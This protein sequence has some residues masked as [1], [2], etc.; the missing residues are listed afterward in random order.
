MALKMEPLTKRIRIGVDKN[1]SIHIEKWPMECGWN[2][3]V[4]PALSSGDPEIFTLPP[5]V[6]CVV[7]KLMAKQKDHAIQQIID[8]HN[9]QPEDPEGDYEEGYAQGLLDARRLVEN[10]I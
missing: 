5:D 7:G 4:D 9:E 2:R 8:L 6:A 1:S 3:D 10:E